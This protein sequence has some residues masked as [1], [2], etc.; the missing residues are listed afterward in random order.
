M[1]YKN[2]EI[3]YQKLVIENKSY[4]QTA[5]ELKCSFTAVRNWAIKFGL[6]KE[7]LYMKINE[8][9]G[10]QIIND[11]LK[12]GALIKDLKSKYNV[13]YHVIKKIFQLNNIEI[14]DRKTIKREL[15]RRNLCRTLKV[16]HDYFKT[17]S[18][19]FDELISLRN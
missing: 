3:M 5:K 13:D 15:D 17:W 16:N 1:Q 4:Q 14:E 10:K 6:N 2:K 18:S 9:I 11:Y 19:K 12:T 7:F 8:Q